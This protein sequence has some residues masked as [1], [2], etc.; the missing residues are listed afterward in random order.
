[1]DWS[2]KK[3]RDSENTNINYAPATSIIHKF[4]MNK[5]K[6]QKSAAYSMQFFY[7]C[8]QIMLSFKCELELET[9]CERTSVS[10]TYE[11]LT[12][13]YFTGITPSKVKFQTYISLKQ[14]MLTLLKY[15]ILSKML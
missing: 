12:H 3:Q 9:D 10:V 13:I 2:C 6:N 11:F 15:Y 8:N 14:Q 5:I 1:M 4:K 7:Y